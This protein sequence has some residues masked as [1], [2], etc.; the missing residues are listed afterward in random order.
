[1]P[2]PLCKYKDTDSGEPRTAVRTRPQPV[3]DLLVP[4]PLPGGNRVPPSGRCRTLAGTAEKEPEHPDNDSAGLSCPNACPPCSDPRERLEG[5]GTA[6]SDNGKRAKGKVAVHS[7]F[8]RLV[9]AEVPNWR[10]LWADYAS[11]EACCLLVTERAAYTAMLVFDKETVRVSITFQH[12]DVDELM[13]R[14]HLTRLLAST[15]AAHLVG[16]PRNSE[17]FV[18]AGC[19]FFVESPAKPT[20][21]FLVRELRLLLDDSD[22][23][24]I[25]VNERTPVAQSRGGVV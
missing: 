16:D 15:A 21:A 2:D 13:G 10:V 5:K 6:A 14:P 3:D 24:S 22:L 12:V 11:H 1:M 7:P 19:P 9:G 8:S 20:V 23:S 25:L 17:A 18:I 4:V